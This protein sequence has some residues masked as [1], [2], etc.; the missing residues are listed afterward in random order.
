MARRDRLLNQ[1]GITQWVVRNPAALRGERGIRIPDSTKL[2]IISD[3]NMDLNSHLLK[4][5]FLAM[6]IDPAE[7]VCINSEQL[8]MLPTPITINC[9]VLGT[10]FQ[11]ETLKS[12]FISPVLAELAMSNSAKRALWKQIYQNDENFSTKAV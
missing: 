8:S 4:D 6:S 2:I 3:D 11:P 7:V 12:T 5:I 1:M 10:E 9:W